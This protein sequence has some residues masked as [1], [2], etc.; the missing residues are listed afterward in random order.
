M[1]TQKQLIETLNLIFE[2]S[3]DFNEFTQ[4]SSAIPIRGRAKKSILAEYTEAVYN[5]Y[6]MRQLLP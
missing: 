3:V 5:Y 1:I 2:D 4:R 6:S